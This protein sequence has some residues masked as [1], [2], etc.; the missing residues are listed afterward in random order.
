[1][2]KLII[3]QKLRSIKCLQFLLALLFSASLISCNDDD[4]LSPELLTATIENLEIGS[5]NNGKGIIG[6]DFHFDMDVVAATRIVDI[7]VLIKQKTGVTYSKDWSF[8]VTWEE[9]K[10][11]KNTNVHKHFSI[12][13]EAPEGNYDFII[14]VKDENGSLKE[15]KHLIELI[16]AEKLPVLPEL[17]SFML[18]KS[19]ASKSFIYILNRGFMD[20]ADKGYMK[21]D[22]LDAYVDIRNV[23]DD[24]VIYTLLIKKSAGHRPETVKDIDFSK[25]I[26]ADVR[27]HKGLTKVGTFTNYVDM[28]NFSPRTL[29]I[30]GA[31]DNNI[32]SAGVIDQSKWASGDYYY[33][34]VYTNTTHNMSAH[35]YIDL[36]LSGF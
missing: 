6:R 17:Y 10:G 2:H 11:A 8:D 9:F 13:E 20:P 24:G 30:G 22:T 15:E 27:E 32:P 1:M 35:Y 21:G 26:V 29:V 12:P 19:A 23:K 33:G 36:S 31:T 3:K 25:V 14:R 7:Q 5:G 16:S 18:Q 28:P 4:D 34:I